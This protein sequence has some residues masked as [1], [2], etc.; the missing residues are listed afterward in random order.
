MEAFLSAKRKL[1]MA[2]LELVC[3]KIPNQMAEKSHLRN[4]L[5]LLTQHFTAGLI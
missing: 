2:A 5:N 1:E 4:L 3:R